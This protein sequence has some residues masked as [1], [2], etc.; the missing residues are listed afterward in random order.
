MRYFGFAV[1]VSAATLF[2]ACGG[3]DDSGHSGGGATDAGGAAG[4]AGAP[5]SGKGG[6]PNNTAGTSTNEGG[7]GP[8]PGGGGEAGETPIGPA[9]MGKPRNGNGP[10]VDGIVGHS[11]NFTMV[12]S[13][14]EE[15]GGST[16]MFSK[17]YR[18]N[19]GVVGSTQK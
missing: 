10:V 3:D 5:A 2:F 15:P 1:C 14:G 4:D 7:D 6:K 13:I 16:S 9:S 18:V 12:L 17:A 8:T 11:K 19:L